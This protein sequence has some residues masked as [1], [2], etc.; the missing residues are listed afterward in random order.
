[1]DLVLVQSPGKADER[2]VPLTTGRNTL[3]SAAENHIR[4]SSPRI[5]KHHLNIEQ[6]TEGLQISSAQPDALFSY[7]GGLCHTAILRS[8]EKFSVDGVE[9]ECRASSDVERTQLGFQIPRTKQEKSAPIQTPASQAP[10]LSEMQ[11]SGFVFQKRVDHF[12]LLIGRNE[13]C[14]VVLKTSASIRISCTNRT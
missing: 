9:F 13:K 1:M 10:N 6:N 7:A 12:P 14:D 11:V 2:I 3:G 8:G 4:I 5:Q